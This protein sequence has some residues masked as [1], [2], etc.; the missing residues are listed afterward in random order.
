MG[1]AEKRHRGEFG[2]IPWSLKSLKVRYITVFGIIEK[3]IIVKK[4]G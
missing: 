1:V 4:N 3:K 2:P